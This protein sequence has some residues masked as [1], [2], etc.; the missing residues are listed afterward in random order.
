MRLETQ[1]VEPL[2]A[3]PSSLKKLHF[4]ATALSIPSS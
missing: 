4:A 2:S 3:W 1:F